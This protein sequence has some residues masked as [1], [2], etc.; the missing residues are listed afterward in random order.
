M[1][2]INDFYFIYTLGN[3]QTNIWRNLKGEP[4]ETLRRRGPAGEHA[5]PPV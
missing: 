4:Q 3:F 1:S 2:T 5:G